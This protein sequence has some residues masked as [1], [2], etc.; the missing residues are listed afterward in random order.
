M[1]IWINPA[2]SKCRAAVERL[3]EANV[4]HAVRRYLEDPPTV[5]ELDEALVRLGM[6][7][8]ELARSGDGDE[9]IAALPREAGYRAEWLAAMV[10]RPSLIQRPVLL[11]DDGT[12]VVGRTPEALERAISIQRGQR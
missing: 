9:A 12:A 3:D 10:A 8:W 1:E 5:A 7:P 4:P 11:L 6:Q 2:C